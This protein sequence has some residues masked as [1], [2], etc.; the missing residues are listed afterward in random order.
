VRD[1]IIERFHLDP[2]TVGLVPLGSEAIG[3]PQGS[4]WSGIALAV[5]VER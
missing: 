2:G 1:Y 4:T 5:F 3:S